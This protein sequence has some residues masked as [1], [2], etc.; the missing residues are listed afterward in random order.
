MN[1]YIISFA[2]LIC[3][4]GS[5]NAFPSKKDISDL[6][7]SQ[8]IATAN[9]LVKLYDVAAAQLD[10]A[11]KDLATVQSKYD[12]SL[13]QL[14]TAQDEAQKYRLEAHNN[15]KQRDVVVFGFAIF[16]S[17]W[18]GSLFGNLLSTLPSPWGV[19]APWIMYA[20]GL[21]TGYALGRYILSYLSAF[22]P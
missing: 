14:K 12:L 4:V 16:F 3:G 2:L 20:V 13:A 7:K 21:A 22:I 6:P 8:I 9:S 10:S 19:I 15:A 11:K 5:T 18:F 17:L 1:K